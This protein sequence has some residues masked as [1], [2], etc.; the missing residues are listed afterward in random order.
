MRPLLGTRQSVWREQDQE[1]CQRDH[2]LCCLFLFV[3][4]L[5][6]ALFKSCFPN[7][8]L[9]RSSGQVTS[10]LGILISGHHSI[11]AFPDP[12]LWLWTVFPFLDFG[13]LTSFGV[14]ETP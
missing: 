3:F 8:F 9:K 11:T 13:S 12:M 7:P 1:Q 4:L 14:R 5:W 2:S 6:R 10:C